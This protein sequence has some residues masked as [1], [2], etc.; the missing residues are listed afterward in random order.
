[1][2]ISDEHRFCNG[3]SIIVVRGRILVGETGRVVK[4]HPEYKVLEFRDYI[5]V[6]VLMD[7]SVR[8]PLYKGF[9]VSFDSECLERIEDLDREE[10][11]KAEQSMMALNQKL[12]GIQR[13]ETDISSE[14]AERKKK[15]AKWL[16]ELEE[17]KAKWMK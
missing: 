14:I 7:G 15:S 13:L 16:K 3:D 1:M 9:I 8:H 11:Y 17:W 2:A 12:S 6:D 4:V 10:L 5:K